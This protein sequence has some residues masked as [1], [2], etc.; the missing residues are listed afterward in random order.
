MADSH[1]HIVATPITATNACGVTT[2]WYNDLRVTMG[3]KWHPTT[4][5]SST[6]QHPPWGMTRGE[7][8]TTLQSCRISQHD[9]MLP[10]DMIAAPPS[11]R[12]Q[13]R[14]FYLILCIFL[15]W[16]GHD[17]NT[18]LSSVPFRKIWGRTRLNWTLTAL[19]ATGTT[20]NY[21]IIQ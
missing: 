20:C 16:C 12:M 21:V 17:V 15:S 8:N 1:H 7:H 13:G 3:D 14:A 10:T 5:D 11:H 2:T 18:L 4:T 19:A 6:S 9:A